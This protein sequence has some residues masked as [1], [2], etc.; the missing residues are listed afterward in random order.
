M[1]L[2]QAQFDAIPRI[3][4]VTA[5]PGIQFTKEYE[6]KRFLYTYTESYQEKDKSTSWRCS[7]QEVVII[8]DKKEDISTGEKLMVQIASYLNSKGL[9]ADDFAQELQMK[10]KSGAK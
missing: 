1:N 4:E 9:S 7:Q 6:G 10:I 5:G 8:D 3:G 2:T